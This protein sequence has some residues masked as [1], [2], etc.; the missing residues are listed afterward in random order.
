MTELELISIDPLTAFSSLSEA[1]CKNPQAFVMSDE[2]ARLLEDTFDPAPKPKGDT[3]FDHMV[4]QHLEYLHLQ[5]RLR[6]AS[7]TPFSLFG[8]AI[9]IDNTMPLNQVG[10]K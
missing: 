10:V 4:N 8:I 6:R 9:E 3:E 5:R 1:A 2:T 7:L